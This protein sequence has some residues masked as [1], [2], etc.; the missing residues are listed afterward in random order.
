MISQLILDFEDVINVESFITDQIKFNGK[1]VR[2]AKDELLKLD[3]GVFK[4]IYKNLNFDNRSVL[5]IT[6]SNS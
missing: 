4:D 5:R 2:N 6:N 3:Y 1:I